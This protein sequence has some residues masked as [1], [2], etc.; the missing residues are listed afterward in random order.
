MLKQEMYNRRV[1]EIMSKVEWTVEPMDPLSEALGKMKKYGIKE[2]PVVEKGKLKGLLTF[3]TLARRRKMAISSHVKSYMISPPAVK[4]TDKVHKIAEKLVTRDFT[5]LPVTHK[6]DVLGMI[7]RGDIIKILMEDDDLRNMPV[8]SVMN[9]APTT[10]HSG[11]GVKK[12]LTMID[13][14]GQTSAVIVDDDKKMLGCV[15]TRD[16]VTFLE[17]PP[18]RAKTGD[19]SG[20]KVHSDSSVDSL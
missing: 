12:A 13:L 20:E 6:T 4:P 18:Q 7:S 5:S 2:L 9:F 14:E 1:E 3:R 10:I 15:T 19:F 17:T 8:E 16:L 11:I